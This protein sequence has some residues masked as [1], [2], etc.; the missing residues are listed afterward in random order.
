VAPRAWRGRSIASET[1]Q[2][3]P[4]AFSSTLE[5]GS[6]YHTGPNLLRPSDIQSFSSGIFTTAIF[7]MLMSSCSV[8]EV[9]MRAYPLT[10]TPQ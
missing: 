4:S 8:I 10:R 3:T 7:V 6:V 1:G 2:I 5:I 9:A